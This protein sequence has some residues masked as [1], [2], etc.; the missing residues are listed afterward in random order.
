MYQPKVAFCFLVYDQ[1]LQPEI[2][3]A[4]FSKIAD[5]AVV[6]VH[7]SEPYVHKMPNVHVEVIP[8]LETAWGDISIVDAQLAI[9]E[10]ALRHHQVTKVVLL[11]G[12][13]IPTKYPNATMTT[14]L[15]NPKSHIQF[16]ADSQIFPRYDKL[17]RLYPRDR[18]KKH[19]QW[20]ILSR[21]HAS[22]LVSARKN[23]LRDFG[24][25]QIPDEVAIGTYL[26]AMGYLDPQYMELEC[27]MLTYVD[28][29]RGDPYTYSTIRCDELETLVFDAPQI[30]FARK[31]K[32]D[33]VVEVPGRDGYSLYD[34]MHDV[35]G[36]I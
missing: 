3:N 28:W 30:F 35:I 12:S 6:L 2:W 31:F 19:S 8:R 29:E 18:I 5:R 15:S 25:A 17:L 33:T 11:S 22:A 27:P 1:I 14:L 21:L 32:A 34:Y 36:L 4:W 16:A 26:A 20:V 13:T 24:G 9:F 10:A 7:S 23:I